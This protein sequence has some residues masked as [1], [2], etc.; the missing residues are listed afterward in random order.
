MNKRIIIIGNG[1][2]I[3]QNQWEK[4]AKSLDLWK[5]IEN[6]AHISLNY[7]FRYTTPTIACFYDASFYLSNLVELSNI[8]LVIGPN[9][10]DTRQKVMPN[11]YLVPIVTKF[12]ENQWEKGF[13]ASNLV[14]V[15]AISLAINLG[16][17]EII[18]LGLDHGSINGHTHYYED[19]VDLKERDYNGQ[20]KYRGIGFKD[21]PNGLVHRTN[22]YDKEGSKEYEPFLHYK[23]VKIINCSPESKITQFTKIDYNEFYKLLEQRPN[24]VDH[25]ALR[26]EIESF[27]L[28]NIRK[29]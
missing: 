16:Y 18:L 20:P 11:T 14:G 8:P 22:N 17:K 19:E 23:D 28:S 6:E 24:H 15:L 7:S 13:Y 5:I 27:I 26:K 29:G 3:R 25:S 9:K 12:F 10:P 2:S 4:P 1:S 21:H